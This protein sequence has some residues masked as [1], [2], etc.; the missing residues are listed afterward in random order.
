MKGRLGLAIGWCVMLCGSAILPA[1]TASAAGVQPVES[2]AAGAQTVSLGDLPGSWGMR[3]YGYIF[4]IGK[5]FTQYDITS[6]SCVLDTRESL[7][8]ANDDYDRMTRHGDNSF[9]LFQA[10]GVTRYRLD[11]L[12]GLPPSCQAATEA[13]RLD[14]VLNFEALWHA[15]HE[16]Y[17][18]GV[19]PEVL[20]DTH[21]VDFDARRQLDIDAAVAL[22]NSSSTD[23]CHR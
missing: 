19:P 16:N 18:T 4:D 9:A 6:V 7:D 23:A 14:P 10:G 20:V 22:I 5:Q 15:F 8:D 17:G 2:T 13:P 1:F 3:G 12:S 21:G 11:R